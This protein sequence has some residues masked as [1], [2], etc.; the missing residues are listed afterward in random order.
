MD[1]QTDIEDDRLKDGQI[2]R[3]I[4]RQVDRQISVNGWKDRERQVIGMWKRESTRERESA[5]DSRQIDKQGEGMSYLQIFIYLVHI[6][7]GLKKDQVH[8]YLQR[9]NIID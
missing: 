2:Y 7:F 1:R 9:C 6:Y 3:R 4:D 5:T 8:C